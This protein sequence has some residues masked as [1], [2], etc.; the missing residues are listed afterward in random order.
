[1]TPLS[2]LINDEMQKNNFALKFSIHKYN[3]YISGRTITIE[4]AAKCVVLQ[5]KWAASHELVSLPDM[6]KLDVDVKLVSELAID[7]LGILVGIEIDE[8]G[9]HTYI[10]QFIVTDSESHWYF[11]DYTV[12]SVTK[13]IEI[14]QGKTASVAKYT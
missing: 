6:R 8:A 2:K 12:A 4:E 13:D 3:S 14:G 11:F 5:S 1:M 9:E 7:G 10:H